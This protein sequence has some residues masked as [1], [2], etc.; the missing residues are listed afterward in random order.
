MFFWNIAYAKVWTLVCVSMLWL[1]ATEHFDLS[2]FFSY[3]ALLFSSNSRGRSQ[4]KVR[5]WWMIMLLS[6]YWQILKNLIWQRAGFLSFCWDSD[7]IPIWFTITDLII[8]ESVNLEGFTL[9]V[10]NS[11]ILHVKVSTWKLNDD[12]YLMGLITETCLLR[13]HKIL[14][15]Q[16]SRS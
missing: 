3:R 12:C 6:Y 13:V 15:N 8:L 4:E 11:S 1:W 9:T 10:S 16:D 7:S 5:S 2:F 14:E